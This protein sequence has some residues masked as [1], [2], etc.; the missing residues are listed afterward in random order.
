MI[1]TH[2]ADICRAIAGAAWEDGDMDDEE[3]AT[4]IRIA[5]RVFEI[6]K[7]AIEQEAA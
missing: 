4:I 5:Y 3:Q 2:I 6:S 7:A 1:P